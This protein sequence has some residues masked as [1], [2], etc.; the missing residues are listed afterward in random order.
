MFKHKAL[1]T[2][3]KDQKACS[4]SLEFSQAGFMFFV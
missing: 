1:P 3:D 2:S 4:E